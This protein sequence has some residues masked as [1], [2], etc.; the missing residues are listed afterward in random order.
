MRLSATCGQPELFRLSGCVPET[1]HDPVCAVIGVFHFIQVAPHGPRCD[2]DIL[3]KI[4][5]GDLQILIDRQGI[6]GIVKGDPSALWCG[7]VSGLC[8]IPDKAPFRA[9]VCKLSCR[10]QP[11][12]R[13]GEPEIHRFDVREFPKARFHPPCGFSVIRDVIL[14]IIRQFQLNHVKLCIRVSGKNPGSGSPVHRLLHALRSLAVMVAV[15]GSTAGLGADAVELVTESAHVRRIV[16]IAGDDLVDRVDN[17]R[18]EPLVSHPPDH[19][20]HQLIERNRM[21]SEVPDHDVLGVFH[22]NLKRLIDLE[23]SG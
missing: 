14:Q 2:S 18:I 6:I 21:T 7:E 17:Y 23:K 9:E 12:D 11:V 4:I 13:I 10:I 1:F 19:L 3:R 8:E 15:D 22:R 20:W 5:H 16:F